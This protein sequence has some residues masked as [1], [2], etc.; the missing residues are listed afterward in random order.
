MDTHAIMEHQSSAF[1]AGSA[2]DVLAD[3]ADDAVLIMPDGVHRGRAA[4]HAAY[5]SMFS[6]LFKPGTYDFTMDAVHVHG[7]VYGGPLCQDPAG[8]MPNSGPL[9]SGQG[10][11]GGAA[12]RSTRCV[13]QPGTQAQHIQARGGEHMLEMGLG[14]P[15]VPVTAQ[16]TDARPKLATP[17]RKILISPR[18]SP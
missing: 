3:F 14:L 13:R 18:M 7:E 8:E 1:V 10:G 11:K 5:S 6:G 17:S 9:G 2:D 4:I 15:H 12:C 16:S